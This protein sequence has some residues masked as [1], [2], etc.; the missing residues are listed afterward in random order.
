MQ[1]ARTAEDKAAGE[2]RRGHATLC[3]IA[4]GI[5]SA[6]PALTELFSMHSSRQTSFTAARRPFS[7]L[8]A[9]RECKRS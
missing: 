1:W 3:I 2:L 9:K 5:S 8:R 7:M 6:R 4:A